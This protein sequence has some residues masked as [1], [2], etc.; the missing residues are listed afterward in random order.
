MIKV[1][2]PPTDEPITLAEAKANLRVIGTDEDSDIERMI[3]TARQMAEERLNRALMPQVLAFGA[4]GFC[5]ALKVP[6]PPLVEIDSIKYIDADG[7]EQTVPAGY[8]VDEF[9][10]PPMITPAYGTPWPTSRTQAGAVV[11]QYQAGYADAASVPEP[12]RQWM[13]LAIN[14]FYEHRSMVNEGQTY[15]LPEDFHKW[16]IQRYVVYQ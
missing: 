16:L 2:T 3:R 5:G 11:V 10:D 12:I 9:V 1:I 6:R 13:L 15:A 14:A 4:D 8:L 7:A